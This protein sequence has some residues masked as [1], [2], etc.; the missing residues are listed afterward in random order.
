MSSLVSSRLLRGALAADA[1]ASGAVGLLLALAARPLEGPF[2]LP[3][4]FA[5]PTGLFLVAYAL[6]IAAL[7]TRRTLPAAL[8]WAVV[9]ANA[10]W[11]VESVM[12]LMLGW[13]TPTPLGYGF[14]VFQAVAVSVFAELQF[15]GLRRSERFA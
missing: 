2:G 6:F 8:V 9:A 14:V 15:M 1:A 4:A 5:Q 13:L 11:V 12:A 10:L 3:A 7:A